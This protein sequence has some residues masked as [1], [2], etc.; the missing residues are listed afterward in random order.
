MKSTPS[1][2]DLTLSDTDRPPQWFDGDRLST[3]GKKYPLEVWTVPSNGIP[4]HLSNLESY[5]DDHTYTECS[6]SMLAP[7]PQRVYFT[8][9]VV[10]VLGYDSDSQSPKAARGCLRLLLADYEGLILV[11]TLC[12]PLQA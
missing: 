10:N 12:H 9:F 2:I 7:G 5:L 6:I 1:V 11:C 4:F 8:G 3:A